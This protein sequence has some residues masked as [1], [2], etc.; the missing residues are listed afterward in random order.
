[1]SRNWSAASDD[2]RWTPG[3]VKFE[4]QSAWTVLGFIRV[5]STVTDERTLISQWSGA[6]SRQ[7]LLTT[8]N[9]TAPAA[10]EFSHNQVSIVTTSSVVAENVWYLWAVSNDTSGNAKVYCMEL[11]GTVNVDGATG[12]LTADKGNDYDIVL[13]GKGIGGTAD[14]HLGDIAHV[15]YINHELTKQE[16][17]EYLHNPYKVV[18]RFDTFFYV[19]IIGASPEPDWSGN[20]RNFT[21]TG[22]T[23]SAMPP[24]APIF[25]DI[26]WAGVAAAGGGF[27]NLTASI[28][29][30]STVTAAG[31]HPVLDLTA[32][33]TSASTVTATTPEIT[34]EI[35]PASITSGSTVT[36]AGLHPVLDLVAS[37][38]SAS[39]VTAANFT[40]VIDLGAASITSASTVTA[41][42]PTLFSVKSLGPASITSGSTVT[43]TG[44]HPVLDLTA[45]I[46]S[47]STVTATDFQ[48]TRQ[49]GPASITSDSTVTAAGLTAVIDLSA[50]S[51]TSASTVTA[52]LTKTEA[53]KELGPASI[54]SASTVTAAGLHPVLDIVAAITSASTV[55]ANNLQRT[56]ELAA[57]ITSGSTVTAT[58]LHPVLDLIAAVTS[59][60]TVTA[61]GLTTDLSATLGPASITSIS[62]VTAD[63]I[64]QGQFVTGNDFAFTARSGDSTFTGKER[65]TFSS[66]A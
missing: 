1:M 28:T 47:A 42:T 7:F 62:T 59:A 29:S 33:I 6:S 60:S 36:A 24:I 38:T 61:A 3:V 23:R 52:T 34:K 48:R 49:V 22:T 25:G 2:L 44:L 35:G 14:D 63:L 16:I 4:F 20:G 30:A 37:I 54:T 27:K 57:S 65:A 13:G 11:D 17:Q 8:V 15:A 58:G 56:R 39:T 40:A 12:T 64:K 43:A 18:S 21:V 5:E 41:T 19:P 66:Q 45:S 31:L 10:I 50:A 26:S 46:T 53:A 32:S 9:E 51:I 55:T